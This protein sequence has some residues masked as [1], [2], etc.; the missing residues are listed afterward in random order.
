[1]SVAA[2]RRPRWWL[3]AVVIAWLAWIYDLVTNL[4]AVRETAARRH[5]ASILHAESVLHLDPER[6]LDTWLR[7]HPLLGVLSGDYYDNAHFI[8][9]FAVIGWLW[10]RHPGEYRPL[11]SALVAV[12][13][14]GF[15]VFWVYPVAPPRLLAHHPLPDIVA[16]THAIG[17][18]HTGVLAHA[19]NQFASMPSLHLGWATWSAWA[20]WRVWRGRRFA[21]LVW[22][23]P[24]ATTV[25]VMATGNHYFFDCV[26]GVATAAVCIAAS[27]AAY[28]RLGRARRPGPA[29]TPPDR[30]G[31]ATVT[32]SSAAT[33]VVTT[34]MAGKRAQTTKAQA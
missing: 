25:V 7:G 31:R 1:M 19:A 9:T 29:A 23:Y 15:A 28:R 22:L 18:W 8:V 5:G 30:S 4:A 26:A 14:V 17:G 32:A 13:V 3:E 24:A 27:G 2:A 20:A 33:G 34:P 6:A 10:W 11:R 21:P 12:N 16:L